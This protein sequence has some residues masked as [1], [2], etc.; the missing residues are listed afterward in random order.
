MTKGAGVLFNS[1]YMPGWMANEVRTKPV[2][3]FELSLWEEPAI[4]QDRIQS[5]DRMTFTLHKSITIWILK[6]RRAQAQD[7][8]IER[9]EYVDT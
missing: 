1:I 6:G 2:Q 4:R 5:L 3:G 7:S 9:V 8:V